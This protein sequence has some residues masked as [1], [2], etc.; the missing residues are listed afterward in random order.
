MPLETSHWSIWWFGFEFRVL[1]SDFHC[2]SG[3][4]DFVLPGVEE[5]QKLHSDMQVWNIQ[6]LEECVVS[7]KLIHRQI[8]VYF[9]KLRRTNLQ[10]ELTDLQDF[11]RNQWINFRLLEIHPFESRK[12]WFRRWDMLLSL[13]DRLQKGWI[14][15]CHLPCFLWTSSC[16]RV[17]SNGSRIPENGCK[18]RVKLD[19]LEMVYI[20][21][22][23]ENKP[24]VES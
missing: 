4:G 18:G 9:W 22:T 12:M 21:I 5:Y 19:L 8:W 10:T 2:Y 17:M 15:G 3:G 6:N 14:S 24:F 11:V 20:K 7:E 16:R 13:C 1:R 23:K